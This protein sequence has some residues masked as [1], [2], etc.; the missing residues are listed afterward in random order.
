MIQSTGPINLMIVVPSL[1]RA[2]AETQAVDL[3][4]GLAKRG[5]HV[6]MCSFEPQL[7]QR[8][9]LNEK[10]EFHHFRRKSKFDRELVASLARLIDATSVQ[11]IQGVM[12]YA[13]LYAWRASMKSAL[14]PVVMATIH[15]TKNVG[16]KEELQDRLIYRHMLRKLPRILFVCQ[17]QRSHWVQKFAEL[18][19]KSEV[20][21]NGVDPVIYQR[22][23]HI[24]QAL[25]LK[26]HLNIPENALVFSCIAAF[27]R[28]KGHEL[29]L[30]AFATL[31]PE[32]HLILA[33]DGICR[34]HIEQLV[35][36]AGLTHRIHFL[37]NVPD[38]RPVIVASDATVLASTA[39]ETFSMAMLESMALGV[40][41]IAPDIGGLA[42]A[43][44]H[45]KTG[46]LFR[47]GDTKA[48][49]A[50]LIEAARDRTCL[51]Q[52]GEYAAARVLER[53]SLE[54]MVSGTE[55]I[56]HDVLSPP[57]VARR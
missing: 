53:F 23:A 12:Q 49:S 48:L 5:H 7:N 55:A 50:C 34:P 9:R 15:T 10:V 57:R 32:A 22:E 13:S 45:G 47:V 52:L 31:P 8:V 54:T 17:N 14:Q 42:E 1:V 43:I 29:L 20:V 30:E 46:F 28:E 38:V 11:L 25:G 40:P 44:E 2:G 35:Q 4:N 16:L 36:Q 24:A 56:Y 37:G 26:E 41:V 18:E 33:G 21:Y 19:Q 51:A 27:R 39:V 6:H 3:A